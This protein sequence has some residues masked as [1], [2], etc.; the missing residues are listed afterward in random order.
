MF[1]AHDLDQVKRSQ[2]ASDDIMAASLDLGGTITGEHGV[3]LLKREYLERELGPV[4]L[5]VHRDLKH[6]LDPGGIPQPWQGVQTLLLR[7]VL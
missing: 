6:A 3:G 7:R 5:R 1:D 4:S 2:L